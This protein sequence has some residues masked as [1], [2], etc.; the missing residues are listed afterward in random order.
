MDLLSQYLCTLHVQWIF[1][2]LSVGGSVWTGGVATQGSGY[3]QEQ[4][5][6]AGGQQGEVEFAIRISQA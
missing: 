2:F 5:V 6:G 3:I 4:L 1:V